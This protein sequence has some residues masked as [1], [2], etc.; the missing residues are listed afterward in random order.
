MELKLHKSPLTCAICGSP[1][2]EFLS[3]T[4]CRRTR[5]NAK[6]QLNA[7]GRPLLG[8]TD[9]QHLFPGE[10]AAKSRFN[11]FKVSLA[12]QITTLQHLWCRQLQRQLKVT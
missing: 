11:T 3:L 2:Q 8:P 6:M 12:E 10:S 5:K 4:R 7:R 1:R 9:L